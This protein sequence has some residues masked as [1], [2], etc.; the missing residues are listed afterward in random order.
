MEGLCWPPIHD[1]IDDR[2]GAGDRLIWVVA[3]FIKLEALKRLLEGAPPSAGFKLV[4]R[5]QPSDLVAGVSDLE[6][7]SYLKDRGWDLFVNQRIHLKLYVFESNVA[8]ATSGN[9]TMSGLGYA[10][11]HRANVEVGTTVELTAPDWVNLYRV[12]GESRLV[13][14]ELYARFEEYV[15]A[16]PPP[17]PG[18]PAPDLLGPPK[19]Y[20]LASLPATETP[21]A[22]ADFYF[23]LSSASHSPDIARRGYHDLATFGIPG[24]LSPEEFDIALGASLRQNPFV[25]DFL[26]YL[27]CQGSL[28]FGAVNDWIHDRCED[29]PLPYRW[30]VKPSTRIFYN[31]LAHYF[32]EVTWDRPKF[33]QVIFWNRK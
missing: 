12:T 15:R 23:S 28:R 13:T 17:P 33:S 22:L 24:G 32:S 3:P 5:W 11:A 8:L 26:E 31:W 25:Q 7:Y 9:L 30:E 2:A 4:C 18:D 14:P 19:K 29:V 6:V 21:A 10:D 16:H 20:T 1:V 27:R